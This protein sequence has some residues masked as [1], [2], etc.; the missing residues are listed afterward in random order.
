METAAFDS[1]PD[2]HP[3]VL[4]PDE[5]EWV[6]CGPARGAYEEAVRDRQV[7]L[8]R[9]DCRPAGTRFAPGR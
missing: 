8:L 9:S 2:E 3:T 1:I 7:E 4:E 6:G 5:F